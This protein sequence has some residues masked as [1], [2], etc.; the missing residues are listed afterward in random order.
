MS[1]TNMELTLDE[2]YLVVFHEYRQLIGAGVRVK[3]VAK[4]IVENEKIPKPS[5]D[6]VALHARKLKHAI[7]RAR[8]RDLCGRQIQPVVAIKIEKMTAGGQKVFDVIYDYLHQMS[9]DHALS[10]FEQKDSNI[11]KQRVASTR[12]LQSCLDFNPNIKGHEDKFRFLFVMEA[13]GGVVE[14]VIEESTIQPPKLPDGIPAFPSDTA[15]G[16]GKER[17]DREDRSPR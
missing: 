4:F 14:E 6:L 7:R 10:H 8:I 15:D 13:S 11:S 1:K 2:Q 3:D 16:I 12:N 17:R 9:L 5:V